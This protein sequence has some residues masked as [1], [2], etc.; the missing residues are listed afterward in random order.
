MPIIENDEESTM[1]ST[2]LSLRNVLLLSPPLTI[3]LHEVHR[4]SQ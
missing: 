3:R 1:D 4:A 2:K